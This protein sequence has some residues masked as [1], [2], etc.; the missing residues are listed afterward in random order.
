MFIINIVKNLVILKQCYLNKRNSI[1][2]DKLRIKMAECNN[3]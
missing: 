2:W 1:E 3:E